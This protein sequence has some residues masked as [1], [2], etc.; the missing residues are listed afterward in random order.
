LEFNIKA[1]LSIT[2]HRVYWTEENVPKSQD[3]NKNELDHSLKHCEN[4][5]F[6]RQQGENINF[7]SLAS[8]NPDA[9]HLHGVAAPGVGY[10]WKK[11]RR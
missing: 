7:I 9:N 8:E 2:V 10:N 6:R 4:L 11:R 5:R 1:A 3:F